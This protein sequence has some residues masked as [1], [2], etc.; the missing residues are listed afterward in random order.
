MFIVLRTQ[1]QK[2]GSIRNEKNLVSLKPSIVTINTPKQK[3]IKT[4]ILPVSK[5]PYI[6]LKDSV[7]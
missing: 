1:L 7:G 3:I 6:Q 5:A 2:F 4:N